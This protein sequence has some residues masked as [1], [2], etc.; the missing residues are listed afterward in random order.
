MSDTTTFKDAKFPEL[1]ANALGGVA[2]QI[3]ESAHHIIVRTSVQV[4]SVPEG[5]QPKPNTPTGSLISQSSTVEYS[6]ESY[7]Q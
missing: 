4:N 2:Q 3:P 1:Q 5:L 6:Q 7:E